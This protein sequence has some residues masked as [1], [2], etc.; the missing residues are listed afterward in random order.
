MRRVPGLPRNPIGIPST[1]FLSI[2]QP[3]TDFLQK[4]LAL[5]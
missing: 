3:D 5:P 2:G 4:G 1:A